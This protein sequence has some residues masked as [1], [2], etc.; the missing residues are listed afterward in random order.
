MTRDELSDERPRLKDELVRR[1]R[2][3]VDD[4][5]D[6]PDFDGELGCF[7]DDILEGIFLSPKLHL[8]RAKGEVYRYAINRLHW[9]IKRFRQK[10]FEEM[11]HRGPSLD[12]GRDR[13]GDR[14]GGIARPLGQRLHDSFTEDGGGTEGLVFEGYDEI[15]ESMIDFN[16]ALAKMCKEPWCEPTDKIIAENYILRSMSWMAIE[17]RYGIPHTSA[18]R[19]WTRYILPFLQKAL[20]DYREE[21]PQLGE[22]MPEGA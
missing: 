12:A 18:N 21:W 5:Q 20:A 6:I 15:D 16:V 14:I 22:Q 4:L 3:A 2:I 7:A 13:D 19:R 1:A 10:W 17:Y 9:R 11:K 8:G